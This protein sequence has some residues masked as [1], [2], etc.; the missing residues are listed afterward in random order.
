MF[1]ACPGNASTHTIRGGFFVGR[2]IVQAQSVSKQMRYK[3]EPS[4]RRLKQPTVNTTGF[5]SKK[6]NAQGM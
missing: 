3:G 2:K 5:S 6:R 4:G 1:T